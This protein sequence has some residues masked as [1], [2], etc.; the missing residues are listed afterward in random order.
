MNVDIQNGRPQRCTIPEVA[1]S[2]DFPGQTAVESAPVEGGRN[3]YQR[4]AGQDTLIFVRFGTHETVDNFISRAADLITTVYVLEDLPITYCGEQARE[5]RLLLTRQSLRVY[6]H[7]RGNLVHA[8]HPEE[9]TIISLIGFA[10]NG[11]PI[12][13]G[14]RVPESKLQKLRPQLEAFVQS[15][16][17]L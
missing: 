6:T 4:F 9:R 13:V 2:V 8:E 17:C 10:R 3:V 14:S 16:T 11:V 5:V 12:L 1:L 7:E 15:V